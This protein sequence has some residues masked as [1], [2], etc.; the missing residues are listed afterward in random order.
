MIG[1]H[2]SDPLLQIVKTYEFDS[3]LTRLYL[4]AWDD[5]ELYKQLDGRP[6][7]LELGCL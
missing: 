2:E 1:L 7:Y 5:D 3:Y 4:V 6:I